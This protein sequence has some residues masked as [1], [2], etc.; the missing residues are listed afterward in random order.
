M[1]VFELVLKLLRHVPREFAT[2]FQVFVLE[3]KAAIVVGTHFLDNR[4]YVPDGDLVR[5][6][7]CER[8][9]TFGILHNKVTPKQPSTI[10]Q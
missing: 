3:I 8:R 2:T 9:I 5:L 7:R 1:P 4:W 10:N 6:H